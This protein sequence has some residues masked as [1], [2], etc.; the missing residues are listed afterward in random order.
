MKDCRKKRKET[1]IL[2]TKKS[3]RK[4]NESSTQATLSLEAT[5]IEFRNLAAKDVWIFDSVTLKHMTFRSDWKCNLQ[6]YADE[7]VSLG[8]DMQ[9]T[10]TRHCLR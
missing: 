9:S 2:K 10:R 8:D 1:K 5:K 7:H 3:T 6:Q 4:I